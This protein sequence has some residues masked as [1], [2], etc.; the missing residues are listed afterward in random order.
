MS[1]RLAAVE[2]RDPLFPLDHFSSYSKLIPVTAWIM[3]FI[4]R[5]GKSK[6]IWSDHGTNFVGDLKELEQFL[7]DQKV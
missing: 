2:T 7:S 5:R 4:G 3:R 1:P 6:V